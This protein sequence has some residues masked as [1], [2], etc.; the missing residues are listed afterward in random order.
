VEPSAVYK[1]NV[2]ASEHLALLRLLY[3]LSWVFVTSAT[4]TTLFPLQPKWG[5]AISARIG[6]TAVPD[7]MHCTVL[8]ACSQVLTLDQTAWSLMRP[9][10]MSSRVLSKAM[11]AKRPLAAMCGTTLVINTTSSATNHP[12]TNQPMSSRTRM[13]TARVTGTEVPVRIRPTSK[14][15]TAPITTTPTYL[16]EVCVTVRGALCDVDTCDV[17]TAR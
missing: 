9:K 3:L 16:K 2:R 14:T 7:P 15:M 5:P 10:V 13:M 17:N 4:S 1:C 6:S 8:P 12:R 11:A